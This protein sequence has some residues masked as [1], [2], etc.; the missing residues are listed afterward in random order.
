M[1]P[2]W[3]SNSRLLDLQ[4]VVLLPCRSHLPTTVYFMPSQDGCCRRIALFTIYWHGSLL[5]QGAKEFRD[6]VQPTETHI[7]LLHLLPAPL[8]VLKSSEK[9]WKNFYMQTILLGLQCAVYQYF[10]ITW[11]ASTAIGTFCCTSCTGL[12]CLKIK[13][14][15]KLCFPNPYQKEH[16]IFVC[17]CV[18]GWKDTL[19]CCS[20]CRALR[21]QSSKNIRISLILLTNCFH[22]LLYAK[23]HYLTWLTWCPC[24]LSKLFLPCHSIFGPS[25]YEIS[26]FSHIS[27]CMSPSTVPWPVFFFSVPVSPIPCLF[28]YVSVPTYP[29]TASKF[30]LFCLLITTE[31][32][33][34]IKCPILTCFHK[35]ATSVSSF[36]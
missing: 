29:I 24:V 32:P 12:T 27:L 35:G 13:L 26:C 10:L 20:L 23:L 36:F 1:L 5:G 7:C 6:D 3:D 11:A 30:C 18:W 34:H 25:F 9:D 17:V 28:Y 21:P 16:G 19:A 33:T 14:I 8:I 31:N 15:K 2:D 4:S 22:C